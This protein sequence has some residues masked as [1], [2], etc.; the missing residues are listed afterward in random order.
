[1][2]LLEPSR[3]D[4]VRLKEIVKSRLLPEWFKKCEALHSGCQD[5][6]TQ[7]VM[8]LVGH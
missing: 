7:K 5:E 8:P 1:M 6:W 3:Q 4:L 2:V